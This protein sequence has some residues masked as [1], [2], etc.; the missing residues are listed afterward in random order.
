MTP[1]VSY[2]KK[3]IVIKHFLRLKL[4]KRF[5]YK[6]EHCASMILTI[7]PAKQ[8]GMF[9]GCVT[10]VQLQLCVIAS[11]KSSTLKKNLI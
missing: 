9:V 3:S 11:D 5:M 8:L 4:I 7:E 6:V 2:F 1:L 10:F